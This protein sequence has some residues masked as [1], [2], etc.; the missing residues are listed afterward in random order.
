MTAQAPQGNDRSCVR[1]PSA[2]KSKADEPQAAAAA[3]ATT[4]QRLQLPVL[5]TVTQTT[6]GRTAIN[7]ARCSV[8]E[9]YF[10]ATVTLS[11]RPLR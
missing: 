8:I 2:Y 4:T 7:R 3:A 6:Y 10:G 5:Q 1:W 11:R 9:T